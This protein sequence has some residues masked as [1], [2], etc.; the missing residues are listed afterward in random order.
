[1][2]SMVRA[3]PLE[4]TRR[5]RGGTAHTCPR[6]YRIA[7]PIAHVHADDPPTYLVHGGDYRLVRLEQSEL[8]AE[9]LQGANVPHRLVKLPWANHSFDYAFDFSW[10]GSGSQIARSTLAEFLYD[11]IA[12]QSDP[13]SSV[14]EQDE[15]SD[16]T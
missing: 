12:A 5:F 14:E 6:R 11:H 3:T 9:R 15:S 8:L 4:A 16:G 7:S 2:S 1:M 10:S 13:M